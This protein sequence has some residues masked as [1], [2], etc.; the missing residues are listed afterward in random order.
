[1]CCALELLLGRFAQNAAAIFSQKL[2]E[3]NDFVEK[4]FWT[5]H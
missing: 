3:S 2:S 1:M 5:L 4:V